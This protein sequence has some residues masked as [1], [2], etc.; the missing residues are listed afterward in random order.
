MNRCRKTRL[1]YLCCDWLDGQAVVA[2]LVVLLVMLLF[3]LVLLF[4]FPVMP[5]EI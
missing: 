2:C 5:C 1:V 3:L 4:E